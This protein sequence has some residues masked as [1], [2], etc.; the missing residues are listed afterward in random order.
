M[1]LELDLKTEF[2]VWGDGGLEHM[3]KADSIKLK[4]DPG[5]GKFIE[6]G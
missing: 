4:L 2:K 1:T 3:K 5:E 6:L